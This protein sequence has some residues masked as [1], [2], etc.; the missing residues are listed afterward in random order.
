[1]RLSKL[2]RQVLI[3]DVIVVALMTV[4]GFASH[5]QFGAIGR[6]AL[7]FVLAFAG[8]VWFAPWFGLFDE[9]ICRTPGRVWWRVAWAWTAV[10]PFVTVIRSLVLMS[11]LNPVFTVVFTVTQL[12]A[13]VIWRS[14]FGWWASR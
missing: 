4:I 8:W 14:A 10:G 12:V 3:G 9:S 11:P 5:Q 6:M 7:T 13:F 1:M 2:Q